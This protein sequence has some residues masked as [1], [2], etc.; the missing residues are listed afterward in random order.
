MEQDG[1]LCYGEPAPRSVRA[2]PRTAD[3]KP[4]RDW[5]RRYEMGF[6]VSKWFQNG[7]PAIA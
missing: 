5:L 4:F 1:A 7:S 3:R 6:H 2:V